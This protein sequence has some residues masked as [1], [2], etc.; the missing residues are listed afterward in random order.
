M[1]PGIGTSNESETT[2]SVPHPE[3]PA[4]LPVMRLHQR[5]FGN[6]CAPFPPRRLIPNKPQPHLCPQRPPSAEGAPV[7]SL[8]T[9]PPIPH[10]RGKARL[11][12]HTSCSRGSPQE[13]C[14]SLPRHRGHRGS[15]TRRLPRATAREGNVP[16]RPPHRSPLPA[17]VHTG[18]YVA[19]RS[20]RKS[21]RRDCNGFFSLAA[22]F[23]QQASSLESQRAARS[24]PSQPSQAPGAAASNKEHGRPAPFATAPSYCFTPVERGREPPS[25]ASTNPASP[26]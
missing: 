16:S 18:G 6:H 26:S 2:P 12:S 10:L 23:L 22:S 9:R 5:A 13:Q 11:I 14:L 19:R 1:E 8:R 21:P 7:S 3:T 25:T 4:P 17:P 15:R 20:A 24:F